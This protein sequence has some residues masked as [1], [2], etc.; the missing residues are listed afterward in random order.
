VIQGDMY[1]IHEGEY[2]LLMYILGSDL[3]IAMEYLGFEL[4][5]SHKI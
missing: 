5:Q 3:L 2:F 1:V 4:D